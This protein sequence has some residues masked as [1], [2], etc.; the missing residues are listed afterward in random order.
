MNTG[1]E[2]VE[3]A[4]KLCRKWAYEKKDIPMNQAK[5][6]VCE[7]NFH[8]R[9]M[10]AISASTSSDSRNGFG[11]FLPGIVKIP[12]NDLLALENALLDPTIAGFLVEPIQ[13]E[14][15]VIVPDTGYIIGAFE[16]CKKAN[17]LFIADEVQTG[18]SRTGKLLACNY[19]EVHPD[20][21]ILGKALSG[22]VLPV[23]AVLSSTEIMLCIRPGE[24]GSTFGGN[25]LACAV[26]IAALEVIRDENLSENSYSM[27]LIFRE[28]IKK[29]K[30]YLIKDMRGM[31]LMNAIEIHSGLKI[32]AMDI[33]IKLMHK[34]ILAKPTHENT[35]RFTPPLVISKNELLEGIG[36]IREVFAAI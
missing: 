7:N 19:E 22:G 4:F 18:I 24:H 32:E 23:S 33:C 29:F 34:G 3:T 36:I 14:A 31:G 11:P 17:V 28:E 2:A 10:F 13:G 25:P 20:I 12:F 1:V 8:G 5:I 21:L 6:I 9:T 16:R 26:G 15:G 30:S 27:G 35:I